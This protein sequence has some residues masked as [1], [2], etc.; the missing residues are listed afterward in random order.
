MPAGCIGQRQNTCAAYSNPG[1]PDDGRALPVVRRRAREEGRIP[2]G[3]FRFKLGS[4]LTGENSR[5]SGLLAPGRSDSAEVHS[6]LILRI[7]WAHIPIFCVDAPRIV[8]ATETR[9]GEWRIRS[10]WRKMNN[11]ISFA[12]ESGND[13]ASLPCLEVRSEASPSTEKLTAAVPQESQFAIPSADEFL[14]VVMFIVFP[15]LLGLPRPHERHV[16]E[17]P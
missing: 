10:K 13:A 1:L 5:E 8:R 15:M 7:E 3:S 14:A 2:S 17:F 9:G 6:E 11:W 4:G 12:G 16:R